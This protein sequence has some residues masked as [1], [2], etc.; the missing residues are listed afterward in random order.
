LPERFTTIHYNVIPA[1][2]EVANGGLKGMKRK[3]KRTVSMIEVDV[4]RDAMYEGCGE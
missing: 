4:S 1:D 2:D 3:R